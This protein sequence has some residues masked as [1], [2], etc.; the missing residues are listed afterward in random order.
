MS[1]NDGSTR[2]LFDRDDF[3]MKVVLAPHLLRPD[4]DG[5]PSMDVAPFIAPDGVLGKARGDTISIVRIGAAAKYSVAGSLEKSVE[6][7][8]R[9]P[10]AVL[11]VHNRSPADIMPSMRPQD[12]KGRYHQTIF[13][14][15][16]RD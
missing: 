8:S 3:G 15:A 14:G 1:G 12:L 5:A 2:G 16:E 7:T 13:T 4:V 11:R 10:S 6:D 9:T